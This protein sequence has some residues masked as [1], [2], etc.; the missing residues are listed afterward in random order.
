[1]GFSSR[2]TRWASQT[3]PVPEG[4]P[5]WV[6][7]PVK[8][9]IWLGVLVVLAFWWTSFFVYYLVLIPCGWLVML[10]TPYRLRRQLRQ[11]NRVIPQKRR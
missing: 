5:K 1:M 4:S 9:L 8:A 7:L 2:L 10:F 11:A 6:T 3:G